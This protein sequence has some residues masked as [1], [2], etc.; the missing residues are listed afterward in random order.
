MRRP[1]CLLRLFSIEPAVLNRFRKVCS[2]DALGAGEIR[3]RA[4]DFENAVIAACREPQPRNRLFEQ[5]C[6]LFVRCAVFVDLAWAEPRIVFVLTP[7]HAGARFR[8]TL[9]NDARR[10]TGARFRE[11]VWRYRRHFDLDVDEVEQ[12]AGDFSA[13]AQDLVG[14]AM[15]AAVGVA[16]EAAGTRI[17]RCDKLKLRLKI[18]LA[19]EARPPI[20]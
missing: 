11:I 3:N 2:D 18:R 19:R 15:A 17:H 14:R 4:R 10:F 9:S 7:K 12:R 13:V 20:C 8:H 1:E 16:E 6:A 5:H